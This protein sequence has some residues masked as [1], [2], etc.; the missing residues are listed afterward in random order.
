METNEDGLRKY[1]KCRAELQHPQ[2]DWEKSWR[3]ARLKGLESDQISLLWRL[4]HNLLPT[5][6]RI[7]RILQQ[8]DTSCRLCQHHTDDLLHL[9]SCTSSNPVCQVLLRTLRTLQPNI[10]PQ[11][12][13]LLSLNLEPT[14]ELPVVWL[15]SSTL[16]YVWT[17]KTTKKQCSLVE[18][19][20]TL[21]ARVNMLR[22]GK[23]YQNSASLIDNMIQNFS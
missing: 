3:L 1:I 15:V 20:A 23:K 9:F 13:L 4:L 6:S 14:M 10:S 17:Q 5:Q 16:L 7:S 22:R 12:I 8:Q 21:E 19:R 18:V 11:Q 2:N